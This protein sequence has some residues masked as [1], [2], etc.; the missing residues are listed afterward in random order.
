MA[1]QQVVRTEVGH[2]VEHGGPIRILAEHSFGHD[3]MDVN[4]AVET[5]AKPVHEGHSP[6]P[7]GGRDDPGRLKTVYRSEE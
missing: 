4:V 1:G 3:Y 7:G 5:A 2:G 6:V